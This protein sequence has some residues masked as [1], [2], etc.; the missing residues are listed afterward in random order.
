[1]GIFEHGGGIYEA[2][3]P[4]LENKAVQV[5]VREAMSRPDRVYIDVY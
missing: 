2:A 5:E 4:N 1:M 3:V